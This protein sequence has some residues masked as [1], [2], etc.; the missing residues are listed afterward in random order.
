MNGTEPGGS[1]RK[2]A[3]LEHL[4]F[5]LTPIPPFRL[6]L[7]AWALRRRPSNTIDVWDGATYRRVLVIDGRPV[8]VAVSQTGSPENSRLHVEL[9]GSRLPPGA[10][11]SAKTMLQRMLGLQLNLLP[12]YRLVVRDKWAKPLVQHFRG[13]KPPRFPTVFEA[14]VNGIACQQLTLSV[15]ILLLNRL[16]E[17]FGPAVDG[18]RS[19]QHAFPRPVDLAALAPST[20]RELGFSTNKACALIELSTGLANGPLD[21]DVLT[22]LETH[23]ALA[24][25]DA[26]HGVGRWTAEYVLL[27]GIGRLDVFPGD[28]VGARNNLARFLR[29]RRPLDYGGAQQAVAGWQPY[30]GFLYFHL[31]LE[32]IQAAGWLP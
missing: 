4:T 13:V 18:D 20:L 23:D 19:A 12:F 9:C 28:D 7:T 25:L 26:L 3:H 24:R 32:R 14:L 8:A 22:T 11:Q 1:E 31:L 5:S 27:R 10:K 2:A 15:G 17:R 29:R 6:D 30:A 16:A 21:F